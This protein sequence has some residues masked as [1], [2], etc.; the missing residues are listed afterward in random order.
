MYKLKGKSGKC[1]PF[2][3][4]GGRLCSSLHIR[5]TAIDQPVQKDRIYILCATI[6]FYFH[7]H[8]RN[9]SSHVKLGSLSVDRHNFHD[10]IISPFTTTC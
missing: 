2:L 9:Y 6:F 5:R 7:R 1:L 3:V 8:V 4:T 10:T